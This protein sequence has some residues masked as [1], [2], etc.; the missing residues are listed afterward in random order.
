M[1]RIDWEIRFSDVLIMLGMFSAGLLAYSDAKSEIVLNNNRIAYLKEIVQEDKRAMQH[2]LTLI[3]T[4]LS[5]I[6]DK[7]DTKSD[8][9]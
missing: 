8:K 4:S 1:P 5:R 9:K 7:L 3:R 2:E 6:E